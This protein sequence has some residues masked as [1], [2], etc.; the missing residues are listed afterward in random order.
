[1]LFGDG[2]GGVVIAERADTLKVISP[3]SRRRGIFF[4]Y[5]EGPEEKQCPRGQDPRRLESMG[6]VPGLGAKRERSSFHHDVVKSSP[7]ANWGNEE[8]NEN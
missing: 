4:T 8:K 2:G 1:M 3:T 6:R 7:L 5:K